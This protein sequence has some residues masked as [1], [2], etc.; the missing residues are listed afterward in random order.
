[1]AQNLHLSVLNLVELGKSSL[2]AKESVQ[3]IHGDTE[4]RGTYVSARER[5]REGS[6]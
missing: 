4:D 2:G 6:V 5:A 3:S 1:M